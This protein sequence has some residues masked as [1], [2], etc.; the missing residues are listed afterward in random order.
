MYFLEGSSRYTA[1]SRRAA[2]LVL[3]KA[4]NNSTAQNS[5]NFLF[6]CDTYLILV[7]GRCS[8]NNKAVGTSTYIL[9]LFSIVDRNTVKAHGS[10][11]A[12]K[13]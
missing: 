7:G 5:M 10:Q 8:M 3:E 1:R 9:P 12:M 4:T 6:L 13:F 2:L 11:H